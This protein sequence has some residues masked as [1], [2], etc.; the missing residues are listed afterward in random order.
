MENIWNPS[1]PPEVLNQW[2][3]E[4]MTDAVRFAIEEDGLFLINH[5]KPGI[6]LTFI[7]IEMP[8]DQMIKGPNGK[9]E[10]ACF[11]KKTTL[12]E[13]LTES[14]YIFREHQNSQA[15][16]D[17]LISFVESVESLAKKIREESGI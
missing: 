5:N 6:E 16:R 9:I 13:L 3:Q 11:S 17:E 2:V 1:E 14:L 10:K 7:S 15:Q 8:E 4:N 12:E